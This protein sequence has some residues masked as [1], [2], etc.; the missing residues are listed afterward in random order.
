MVRPD[1][2]EKRH[3]RYGRYEQVMSI[4][5]VKRSMGGFEATLFEND[6]R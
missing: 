2:V 5:G 3:K 4:I 1:E 6:P